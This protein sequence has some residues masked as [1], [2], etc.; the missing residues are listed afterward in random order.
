MPKLLVA[1]IFF[2]LLGFTDRVYCLDEGETCGCSGSAKGLGRD[3]LL[4]NG[5]VANEKSMCSTPTAGDS[6][7]TEGGD[8]RMI[9]GQQ[10]ELKG[11]VGVL[12]EDMVLVPGSTFMMG[13][14]NP[15]IFNDGEGPERPVRVSS[16]LMDRYEVSNAQY[17]AFVQSTKYQTE[18]EVFGWS[19]VFDQAV[20]PKLKKKITQA[21]LGAEWWLPV[22]GS[23]WR[24]PEGPGS[25][26]FKTN[27]SNFPAVHISWT[28]AVKFCEWRNGSRL[29]TEA[30]WELAARGGKTIP[31]IFPWGNKLVSA[32]E[33]RANIFQ[34]TFPK[35]NTGED[36]HIYMAPVD[37][38]GP[39]NDLGLYNMIG[40]VWEWVQDW[41]TVH[42]STELTVNPQGPTTGEEKVKR[43]GSFLCH[44]SFCYRYR[45]VARFKTTPDSATQNGK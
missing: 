39:Q 7:K 18:S 44:R 38:Y 29:P 34:G 13:T 40:N 26:V 43:G 17:K 11:Q 24:E 10:R 3:A 15:I 14:S 6:S 37:S 35:D 4:S 27:R 9:V 28:D 5:G 23:Y 25:D 36:G 1:A 8:V 30:E 31:L 33:H 16:F 42:H 22:N 20:A 45:T 41:W 19:F 12:E 2:F 21:V 32:D